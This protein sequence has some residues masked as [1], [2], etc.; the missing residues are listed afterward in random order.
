[1]NQKVERISEHEKVALQDHLSIALAEP[2]NDRSPLNPL[3]IAFE[4]C[5]TLPTGYNPTKIFEKAST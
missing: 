4:E 5:H 3:A 1:M 2:A